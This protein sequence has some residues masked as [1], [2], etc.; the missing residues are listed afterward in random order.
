MLFM[1]Q[2]SEGEFEQNLNVEQH[3]NPNCSE[4]VVLYLVRNVVHFL[5]ESGMTEL[6][7]RTKTRPT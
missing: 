5:I 1:L 4:L 3:Y 6:K 7:C 2:H